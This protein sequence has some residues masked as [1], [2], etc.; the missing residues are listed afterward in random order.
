[1]LQVR[2]LVL[3]VAAATAFSSSFTYALDLGDLSIQSSVNQPLEA[4]ISLLDV[5][6][7]SAVDIKPQ[8]ASPDAFRQAG[9]DRELFLTSL[10]FTPVLDANGKNVIR[11][12]STNPV[13]NPSLSFLV[14]VLWPNGRL[15]RE[16]TTQ[17][18]TSLY[19][20]EPSASVAQQP[21]TA[22][23]QPSAS[24]RAADY[25]VHKNDTLWE[26][27]LRT[28]GTASVQQTMLALQDLNPDAFVDQNINRLKNNKVLRLPTAEEI[29]RRSR[30]EAIAQVAEQNA[31]WKAG[32]A[33]SAQAQRQLDATRRK[34]AAAAPSKIERT[35]SLRLVSDVPG[36]ASTAADQGSTAELKAVQDQLAISN[37]RLD[38][39]LLE[40]AD[41]SSQIEDLDSQLDKLK[42]LIE[43]KDNQLTQLQ[44]ALGIAPQADIVGEGIDALEA[45]LNL[46]EAAPIDIDSAFDISNV[47]DPL[48]ID[49]EVDESTLTADEVV[50]EEQ[51]VI[52]QFISNPMLLS[53]AGGIAVLA[54]LLLS[55][56]IARSNARKQAALYDEQLTNNLTPITP[57]YRGQSGK[58]A[59]Q[60]TDAFADELIFEKPTINP[61]FKSSRAAPAVD[62]G[63][64]AEAADE[65]DAELDD[66]S[67]L[68]ADAEPLSDPV[69]ADNE[70]DAFGFD[71][72]APLETSTESTASQPADEF[73]FDDLELDLAASSAPEDI[74]EF[75]FSAQLDQASDEL[76]KPAAATPAAT[77]LSEFN[78][79]EF[80]DLQHTIPVA[81]VPSS[82]PAD[83]DD[84]DFLSD[85]DSDS[86]EVAT[87]LNLALAYIDM[88]DTQ[89][90]RDIL[91]EVLAEGTAAQQAEARELISQ[92]G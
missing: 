42:R 25:R 52:E 58:A 72:E 24:T 53:A 75:D 84:L 92:L 68:L 65:L 40:N 33:S 5:R 29:N 50:A 26:I 17:V 66:L 90:A 4:E 27:A 20:S 70:I 23:S 10:V 71:L 62:V 14:E 15:L 69:A 7:L 80:D 64:T 82:V 21:V 35:D 78:L 48:Q 28:R 74:G 31:S 11:V 45:E 63:L 51:S 47:I 59:A 34:T 16:F 54:L 88:D 91:S 41:L 38:S 86:D 43:L 57:N 13:N 56:A 30:A 37:E 22:V 3:A 6:D 87:K 55:L 61:A 85:A 67:A 18:D 12:T 73:S 44:D 77:D 32:R 19:Q 46:E 36:Q 9:I 60:H 89:G 8:L 83:E 76:D 81:D 79:D 1:M 2:K 39:A 49:A